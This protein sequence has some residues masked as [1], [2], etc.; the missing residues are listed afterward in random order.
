MNALALTEPRKRTHRRY[1]ALLRTPRI[2]LAEDDY[3]MRTLLTHRLRKEK[4][5]VNACDDGFHLL[6][7][8]GAAADPVMIEDYDLIISDIRMPG[9]TGLEIL[10]FVSSNGSLTPLILITAFGDAQTHAEAEKLGAVA[11]LDKPFELDRLVELARKALTASPGNRNRKPAQSAAKCES[12]APY[13]LQIAFRN[14]PEDLFLEDCIQ[15][16]AKVLEP[17]SNEILFCRVV[18]SASGVGTPG[19]RL[20][21]RSILMT[22]GKVFMSMVFRN[23]NNVNGSHSSAATEL[24][25]ILAGRLREFHQNESD[26]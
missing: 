10:D 24:F 20:H 21:L 4:F 13:P 23:V 15:T 3:E 16:A 26:R 25:E 11:V 6:Q 14:C 9:F 17:H 19:E 8:L 12:D 5:E 7:E 22:S 18:V 1:A 2:L